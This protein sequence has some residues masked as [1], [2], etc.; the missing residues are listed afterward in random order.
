MTIIEAARQI[1]ACIASALT[2]DDYDERLELLEAADELT[3]HII[4]PAQA[5]ADIASCNSFECG[6]SAVLARDVHRIVGKSG[7]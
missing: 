2:C 5:L 3:S 4:G 6:A 7:E 1:R